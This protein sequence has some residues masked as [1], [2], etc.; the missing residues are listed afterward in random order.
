M[1]SE[2]VN[3]YDGVA[4]ANIQTFPLLSVGKPYGNRAYTY[5]T[6]QKFSCNYPV[7]L[8]WQIYFNLD[9]KNWSVVMSKDLSG[10]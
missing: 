5:E 3:F 9:K 1:H 8:G 7:D 4:I 10:E 6:R 2:F